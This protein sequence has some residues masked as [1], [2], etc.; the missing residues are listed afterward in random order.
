M[1]CCIYKDKLY[2]LDSNHNVSASNGTILTDTILYIIDTLEK[3]TDFVVKT[4]GIDNAWTVPSDS[5]CNTSKGLLQTV[6]YASL[7]G[8]GDKLYFVPYAQQDIGVFD[9]K[10]RTFDQTTYALGYVGGFFGSV[11][12]PTN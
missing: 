3:V 9:L 5:S 11:F 8:Y 4:S 6:S 12:N 10:T 1:G 7:F 2:V